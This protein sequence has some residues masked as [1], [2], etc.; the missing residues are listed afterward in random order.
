M[1]HTP[2]FFCVGISYKN[3]DLDTRGKFSLDET[4]VHALQLAAKEKNYKEMLLLNTCNRTEIY[5]WGQ[6][7]EALKNLLCEYSNGTTAILEKKGYVLSGRAAFH[8]LFRVGTGLESQILGDF[9]VIGQL[10]QSFY[11]AKKMGLVNSYTERLVNAVIQASKRIKTETKI[12]SGA[13]SVAFAA[14]QYIMQHVPSISEKNILL[15]GT[16]KI[17]RNTC[18]N[19]VKHTQ[20]D[21]IVLINRTEE[22]ATAVAKKFPVQ[23]KPYGQ[24]TSQLRNTDL[25]IVATGSQRPTLTADMVYTDKPLLILDLSMPRNVDPEIETLNYVKLIHLDELSQIT[26]TSIKERKKYL[27]KA[28]EI[29]NN[30]EN[31]FLEWLEHRKFAPT[32]KAIK[33]KLLFSSHGDVDPIKNEDAAYMAQKITGQV[34]TYLKENPKKAATTVALLEDI[35]QLSSQEI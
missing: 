27:P 31:E 28:E 32:L 12:S 35:F 13:T 33:E 29:L 9:E 18:E 14:V 7:A 26:N 6:H 1:T 30:I 2:H 8:H 15:F 4:S 20:N 16:G 10:K 24:L 22:K 11:R 19:L 34:A 25:L 3:A 5:A 17:G 21:H 23:V